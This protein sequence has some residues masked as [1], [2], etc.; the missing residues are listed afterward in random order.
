MMDPSTVPGVFGPAPWGA[1]ATTTSTGWI[2]TA[3]YP[4]AEAY[5]PLKTTRR[6]FLMATLAFTI[7]VLAITWF[8]MKRLTAPLAAFTRHVE[9]LLKT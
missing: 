6:Y 2:L 1:A 7:A 4:A 5:A 8:L 9:S 3:N